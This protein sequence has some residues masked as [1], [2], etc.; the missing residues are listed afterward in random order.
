[1][2][3]FDELKA[4]GVEDV[5]FISMD[6][7][8]GLEEGARSIFKDAV[9]Q[10]CIVHLIRNSIKYI[11]SKD[12]KAYTSQ[13]KKVYGAPSLNAA[14][15]EFVRFKQAWDRYPGA[16]AVW[17]RNW[18][19]VKQLFN[20]GSAVRR[21]MYTTNAIEAIN[22]RFRK[23]TK[24]G[25]FPSEDAFSPSQTEKLGINSDCQKI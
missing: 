22:S 3:I 10:R 6:G 12:Y 14:E 25:A 20:Y 7:V 5:L 11:P 16:V 1:M 2:Q 4:R 18:Q 8:S 21:V 13:L 9:V 23:G 24:K 15:A 17:E 19:H